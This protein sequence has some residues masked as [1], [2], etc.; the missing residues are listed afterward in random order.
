MLRIEPDRSHQQP[1]AN[2]PTRPAAPLPSL[3]CDQ[4]AIDRARQPHTHISR[5][6]L[7]WRPFGRRRRCKPR[8]V[9]EWAV[10][11]NPSHNRPAS[12]ALVCLLPPGRTRIENAAAGVY[13]GDRERDGL[14]GGG[15][16]AA[17]SA[18]GDR[19]PDFGGRWLAG[20]V[21]LP[22]GGL[23]EAGW[24]EGQ[25]AGRSSMAGQTISLG[26]RRVDGADHAGTGPDVQCQW[27][28][29]SPILLASRS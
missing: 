29:S 7:P 9:R 26:P 18:A 23:R 12:L 2:K 27:S 8:I 16:G 6:F 4:T 14:A 1:K 15:A 21:G 24:I 13:R 28:S 19:A 11:R 10:I 20:L 17:A 5:G 3:R 22:S 25:N